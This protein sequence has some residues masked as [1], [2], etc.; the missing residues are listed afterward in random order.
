MRNGTNA[1]KQRNR[2]QAIK[3]GEEFLQ[4][5]PYG[6]FSDYVRKI[7][8]FARISLDEEK[9]A[10]A[11]EFRNQIYASL[12]QEKARLEALLNEA[13]SGRVDMNTRTERGRNAL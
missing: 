3:L 13:L 8:N 4:E 10:E 1:F 11:G 6:K 7:I 12:S 9:R 5:Y 2:P